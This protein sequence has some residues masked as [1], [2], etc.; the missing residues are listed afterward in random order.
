MPAV[1]RL[2]ADYDAFVD[3]V[4]ERVDE[5]G[6]HASI[7]TTGPACRK[8]IAKKFWSRSMSKSSA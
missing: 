6:M 7:S 1:A 8:A 2:I 5:M 4:R 3:A